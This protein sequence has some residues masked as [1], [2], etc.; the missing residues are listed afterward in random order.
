M[1][2]KVKAFPIT[3]SVCMWDN[4]SNRAHLGLVIKGDN[5]PG[6]TVTCDSADQ[7]W[8]RVLLSP[9]A[10]QLWLMP[11][12]LRPQPPRYLLYDLFL[13]FIID[14]RVWNQQFLLNFVCPTEDAKKSYIKLPVLTRLWKLTAIKVFSSLYST[15]SLSS[16]PSQQSFLNM[17]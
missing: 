9:L 4:P 13:A 8:P 12:S 17:S 10:G 3:A 16:H 1:A 6:T 2:Y 15:C 14:S 7:T 5:F 11:M